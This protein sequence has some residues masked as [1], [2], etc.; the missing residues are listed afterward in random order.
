MS[1]LLL[2]ANCKVSVLNLKIIQKAIA[3]QEYRFFSWGL[4]VVKLQKCPSFRHSDNML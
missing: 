3:Q 2:D 1:D 4:R